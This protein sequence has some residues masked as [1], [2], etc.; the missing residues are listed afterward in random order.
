MRWRAGKQFGGK[1]WSQ[2]LDC[3][4]FLCVFLEVRTRTWQPG[5]LISPVLHIVHRPARPD[6]RG[7][8]ANA[9]AIRVGQSPTS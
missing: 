7:R 1:K 6:N 5:L 8:F 2:A 9:V 3:G 4:F